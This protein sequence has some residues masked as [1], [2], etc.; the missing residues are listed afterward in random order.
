M[1]NLPDFHNKPHDT[2]VETDIE[3][4]HTV[5][6]AKSKISR[7]PK[8]RKIRNL[9]EKS[10]KDPYHEVFPLPYRKL[11]DSGSNYPNRLCGCPSIKKISSTYP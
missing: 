2:Y 11:Y 3:D 10:I 1:K 4:S 9:L 5:S 7:Q 8:N 6:K